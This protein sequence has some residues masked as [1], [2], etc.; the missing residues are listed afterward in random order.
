MP[1]PRLDGHKNVGEWNLEREN[2]AA[3][4][5]AVGPHQQFAAPCIGEMNF[6]KP[7]RLGKANDFRFLFVQHNAPA[8]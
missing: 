4:L 8:Q 5:G 2:L 1:R 3:I 6:E 7:E